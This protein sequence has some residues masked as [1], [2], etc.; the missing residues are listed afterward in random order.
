MAQGTFC[1]SFQGEKPRKNTALRIP[2]RVV[3]VT[4]C[5]GIVSLYY[6]SSLTPATRCSGLC[7]LLP[8]LWL[9]PSFWISS[10]LLHQGGAAVGL[11]LMQDS[12]PSWALTVPPPVAAPFPQESWVK[13]YLLEVSQGRSGDNL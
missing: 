5:W 1:R 13:L 7:A 6:F 4:D 3:P 2:L 12:L 8:S 11:L 9:T 10:P